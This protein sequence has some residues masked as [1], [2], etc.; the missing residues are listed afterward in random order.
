[1][2]INITQKAHSLIADHFK[3]RRI[4]YAI[5]ATLGGGRDAL[6]LA[7]LLKEGGKV[8]GFD[9]QHEAV[10]RSTK[11]FEKNNLS[12]LAEF[13]NCGHEHLAEK[14]GQFAIGKTGCVMFNLGWLPNSD[15]TCITRPDTTTM[16]LKQAYEI[17]SKSG[18]VL[19]VASYRGH[20]GGVDEFLAVK[21]FFD[22]WLKDKYEVYSDENCDVSPVLF[23]AK[24]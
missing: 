19:S 10:L 14:V 6:F 21:D 15:K 12:H 23:L 7:S 8:F 3:G 2:S 1:M 5:D 4:D 24:F 17:L 20:N 18:G 11:L 16:A 9:V 22:T 13:F